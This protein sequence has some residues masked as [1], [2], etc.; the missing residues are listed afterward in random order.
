MF[1]SSNPKSK[2]TRTA[3]QPCLEQEHF[4]GPGALSRI[5]RLPHLPPSSLHHGDVSR[6]MDEM[7]VEAMRFL[8]CMLRATDAHR[9]GDVLTIFLQ[10][11]SHINTRRSACA[12][13]NSS[14]TVSLVALNLWLPQSTPALSFSSPVSMA[15]SPA[16]LFCASCRRGTESEAPFELFN[17]VHTFRTSSKTM[18]ISS[19]SL[20]FRTLSPKVLLMK[21]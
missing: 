13:P 20:R 8:L 21:P 11:L 5:W 2:P 15:M 3:L 10:V 19:S 6:K 4:F 17:E 9:M 1:L 14:S 12:S 18:R 16:P 7:G